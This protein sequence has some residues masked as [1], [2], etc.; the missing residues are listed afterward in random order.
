MRSA[1]QTLEKEVLGEWNKLLDFTVSKSWTEHVRFP[2]YIFR[3]MATINTEIAS[4][5]QPIGD[6]SLGRGA[7]PIHPDGVT[8]QNVKR[9]I[10]N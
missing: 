5:T 10:L 9:R 4:K 6:I 8:L 7:D 3:Y 1:E 2:S